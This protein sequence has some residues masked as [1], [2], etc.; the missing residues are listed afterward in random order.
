M[1]FILSK[2]LAFALQPLVWVFLFVII[3]FFAKSKVRKKR[4]LIAGFFI[5]YLFSNTFIFNIF[6]K[7]WEHQVPTYNGNETFDVAIVLGGLS[8]RDSTHHQQAF[9]GNSERLFNVLPLY[10]NGKVKKILFA[11][12]SGS[13]NKENIEANHIKAYLLNI[14]VKEQDLILEN[15]S[16]NTYENAKYSTELLTKGQRILLSTS[17]THMPR[18]LACFHKLDFYPTPFPVDYISTSVNQFSF[19]NLFI[20]NPI[21]INRWYWLL[22]EWV[23][24]LTYKLKGYI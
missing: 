6:S 17:A 14:G 15:K 5:L 21:I 13:L 16:R 18:S 10:F 24:I 1:F 19:G 22:H 2:I 9:F 4:S 23:G 20:P 11:G 12:G 3:A 8:G 7:A